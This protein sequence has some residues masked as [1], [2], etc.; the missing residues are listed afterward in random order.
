MKCEEL[1]VNDW[2]SQYGV[3]RQIIFVGNGYAMYEGEEGDPCQLDDKYYPSEPIPLTSE[4][5]E[6]N[7]WCLKPAITASPDIS[8]Q[9]FYINDAINIF[10]Q[11]PTKQ[12]AGLLGIFDEQIIRSLSNFI[13]KDTLYVHE[14]Q[15]LL[16]LCG[17]NCLADNFKI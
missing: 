11:F 16:R 5:L 2:V 12:S 15:H 8:V 10:L 14:L 6:K 7:G 17:L 3:P 13:W 1:M 4:I 9:Q